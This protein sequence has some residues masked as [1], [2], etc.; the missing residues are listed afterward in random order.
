MRHRLDVDVDREQLHREGRR[1][2]KAIATLMLPCRASASAWPRRT[3][4]AL[5]H[6]QGPG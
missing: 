3:E 2:V 1:M 4:A 6:A 5:G